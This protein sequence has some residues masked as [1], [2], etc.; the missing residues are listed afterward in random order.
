MDKKFDKQVRQLAE[1]FDMDLNALEGG[2]LA[3]AQCTGL[4]Q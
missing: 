4:L 2:I 3:L 1:S